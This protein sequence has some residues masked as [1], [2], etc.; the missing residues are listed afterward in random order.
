MERRK[1]YIVVCAALLAILS[2]SNFCLAKYSGGDGTSANPYQISSPND[3]ITLGNT[4]ADYGKCFILTAN[5]DLDSN[6]PGGQVFTK[7]IIAPSTGASFTG[8]FDGNSHSIISLTINTNGLNNCY[9]GLFGQI[10]SGGIIKNLG[11]EDVNIIGGDYSSHIGGLCGSNYY[12]SITNCYVTV[13]VSGYAFIGGLCGDNDSGSIINCYSTGIVSGSIESFLIGG[14]C[15]ENY[16]GSITNCYSTGSVS[17]SSGSYI[18]GGLCG[19]NTGNITDC[20]STGNLS[21]DYQIGGLCGENLGNITDC[22]STGNV[23]GNYTI[24]GLCGATSGNITDCY[25]TGTIRGND[26]TGGLCG[27]T[28]GIITNCYS[29]GTVSG[30]NTIGGLCG[31]ISGNSSIITNCYSSGNITG[32]DY[33]IGGLCGVSSGSIT[34]CYSNGTVSG[35]DSTGG[36]CGENDGD[37]Y[38]S[39]SIGKVSGDDYTGG[40]CGENHDNIANSYSIGNVSGYQRVGGLCGYNSNSITDSYSIGNVSGSD[41]YTGGLCGIN[42]G[43]ITKCYSTGNASGYLDTGG[44]CGW[45]SGSISSCYFLD[46]AGPNNGKGVPLTDAQMRQQMNYAGWD[47][48]GETTNGTDDIWMIYESNS[49]PLFVWQPVATVPNVTGMTEAN[50]NIAI[51][52]SNLVAGITTIYSNTVSIGNV[53]EQKPTAGTILAKGSTVNIVVSLGVKYSGGSGTA[54]DPYKI[55]KPNDLI[56]LGNNTEDY[57]AHFIMVNDINL[58]R[59]IFDDFIIGK[60]FSTY[61]VKAFN[62]VFDGNGYVISNLR[63]N[64]ETKYYVSLFGYADSNSVIKNLGVR[65]V[66]V[67]G[68]EC[69]GGIAGISYGHIEN[70]YCTGTVKGFWEVGGLV[71]WMRNGSILDCYGKIEI[72]G[73]S[74]VGGLAGNFEGGSINNSYVVGSVTGDISGESYIGG[75]VGL[76]SW[77]SSIVN[78]FWSII[79]C[80]DIY[81]KTGRELSVEK[82]KE[83]ETYSLNGWSGCNWTINNKNDYPHLAWEKAVG[84]PIAEPN[85]PLQGSGTAANPYKIEKPE[86]LQLLSFASV[87]WN[88]HF[89]LTNDLDLKNYCITPIGY[90]YGNAFDGSFDG[91]GHIISNLMIDANGIDFVGLI[92]S[93]DSNSVVKN[94]SIRNA[95]IR[96]DDYVGVLIGE[97]G[98]YWCGKSRDGGMVTNCY[99]SG[100]IEGD[101]Y[102]GSL[103]GMNSWGKITDCYSDANVTGSYGVGGLIGEHLGNDI[104]SCYN[105]GTVYG[106]GYTGGLVGIYRGDNLINCYNVGAVNGTDGG[107]GGIVGL[108]DGGVIE[109]CYNTGEINGSYDVGGLVG[110]NWSGDI[111]NCYSNAFINGDYYRAGGLC[112]ENYY[113]NITNCYSTGVVDGNEN[114]GGLCGVNWDGSISSCYFLETAGPDNGLGEPLTDG[115]MKQQ[116]SFINWDFPFTG[117]DSDEWFMAFDGYP[118][119]TWQISDAD[120]YT[121]GKNNLKDWAVFANYWMREDCR[122]YNDFCEFADMDFDGHVDIDDLAEFISYWLE[123]GIY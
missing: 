32:S 50:A 37:I 96:G 15:G 6:L 72:T 81:N 3:L 119:L 47:F 19:T 66:N 80:N 54:D 22:H 28:S 113:G 14:L 98:G 123:E 65:D 51:T 108:V 9:L 35:G 62:G 88:K 34:N 16:S 68:G 1:F 38:N 25:S 31:K 75:I 61:D 105:T 102:V 109:R 27:S 49:Y 11:V 86:D 26:N 106:G 30:D 18:M 55:S 60:R 116:A 64:A 70:S 12:G 99:C 52:N 95:N 87:L 71:G 101:Q 58:A 84:Q 73:Q 29:T 115:Q 110:E 74:W 117:G 42:S 100:I 121:D 120:I 91:G 76:R 114:T 57:T 94:I 45:N 83:M 53:I 118:I 40:L 24:G 44:L 89:I 85:I 2:I 36:L 92:G 23:T 112:G 56:A 122:M 13:A 8:I 97:N 41:S 104:S 111:T 59:Y 79:Y 7:A 78:C 48:V 82:M 21:G 90:G 107:V 67:S 93:A 5:I 77:D 69:V 20:Y 43:S 39:Y 63:I 10:G 4:P 46:T 103:I 17:G 33:S